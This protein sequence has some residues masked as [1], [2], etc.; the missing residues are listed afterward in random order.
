MRE[1]SGKEI[2]SVAAILLG[3]AVIGFGVISQGNAY[4]VESA[5]PK[6]PAAGGDSSAPE[7]QVGDALTSI[8]A[9]AQESKSIL[10]QPS[11][12]QRRRKPK[13]ASVPAG[14][15]ILIQEA[16]QAPAVAKLPSEEKLIAGDKP[17]VDDKPK[18]EARTEVAVR[19]EEPE[20]EESD[21]FDS[22]EPKDSAKKT[23]EA[24]PFATPRAAKT[25][26]EL[27]PQKKGKSYRMAPIKWGARVTETLTKLD[28]KHADTKLYGQ[29]Q[30]VTFKTGRK[31]FF[32]TQTA[33]VKGSTYILQP[34]IAQVDGDV[35]IVHTSEK[36]TAITSQNN[37]E[38]SR[39]RD[40]VRH[41]KFFGTGALALFARSRFPFSA[42]F[43]V[44][45][46]HAASDYTGSTSDSKS[47]F[48]QQEY[49]PPR[50]PERYSANYQLT[51]STSNTTQKN[52]YSTLDGR[53]STKLGQHQLYPFYAGVKHTVTDSY[54]TGDLTADILTASHT[55]LPPESLLAVNS[56]G[57]YTRSRL[58]DPVRGIGQSARFLQLNSVI[59]WQP[60]SE[61]IPL[62]VTGA[63]RYFDAS[64]STYG[65]TFTSRTL[66]LSGSG[67][68][69]E[70]ANLKYQ[71][72]ASASIARSNT[73]STL[74][75]VQRARAI[76]QSDT[77]KFQNS[78]SYNWNANG[79]LINQTQSGG[80]SAN[81]SGSTPAPSTTSGGASQG[82]GS[83]GR[84][85]RTFG[86][87]GHSMQTGLDTS[88]LDRKW[89]LRL[90]VN[91][92]LSA[93]APLT[94]Y[95]RQVAPKSATLRNNVSLSTSYDKRQWSFLGS[96]SFTDMKTWGGNNP[97][98]TKVVAVALGGRGKQP[99]Y[100][101][102]GAKVDGTVQIARS[103]K[104]TMQASGALVGTYLKNGVFGIRGLSYMAKLDMESKPVPPIDQPLGNTPGA[105]SVT[106][107]RAISYGLNQNLMYRVG[108]N[109]LRAAVLTEERRG[110]KRATLLVQFKVWRTIG[111]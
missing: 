9:T 80:S 38:I 110:V 70:S 76:Y 30:T 73:T 98:H 105:G 104:G 37:N 46:T 111:N 71:G 19:P 58:R 93:N 99:I 74:T 67:I 12:S 59:S 24:D 69:D 51:S 18:Y 89:P 14:T 101:G 52:S 91:Q 61:D 28:E 27:T 17:P 11:R 72:D 50:G 78:S 45:N 39:E 40:S 108:M 95:G 7:T 102:Y 86:G 23:V 63:G 65:S 62:F 3:C 36:K 33:Q 2:S 49:R 107:E 15:P 42:S 20:I 77:T 85:T 88:L 55:Y 26:A 90:G 10:R 94:A 60:E 79:G 64:T 4:G 5:P 81:V 68:Y 87:A 109:E 1:S 31:S 82:I 97:S 34:Y 29:N 54:Q 103:S 8:Q 16:I 43:N 25:V 84:N 22:T 56:S 35:G 83:S 106:R 13:M 53:Y 57:G 41:N 21:P 44:A 96:V 32:N 47:V 6:K 48:L 100:E 92:D 75:T 66:S